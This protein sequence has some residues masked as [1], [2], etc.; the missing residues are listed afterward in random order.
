LLN[1]IIHQYVT[2]IIITMMIILQN[3]NNIIIIIISFIIVIAY[4][5]I[6]METEA[7]P[8]LLHEVNWDM[9]SM[10]N[11]TIQGKGEGMHAG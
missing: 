11:S 6:E 1:D 8:R 10:L 4:S 9:K 7:R 2:Y 5:W 3:N